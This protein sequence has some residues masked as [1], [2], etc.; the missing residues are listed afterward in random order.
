MRAGV[1]IV[2]SLLWDTKNGRQEWREKRLAMHRQMRVKV[3]ISYGRRSS[4][5]GNTFTMTLV[6][7]GGPLGEAIL[8]PCAVDP[9]D[10]LDL[11]TEA[12]SLWKAEQPK[13]PPESIAAQW[14]C[15]GVSFGAALHQSDWS[16]RW[17][18]H[19]ATRACAVPPVTA[20][21]HVNI[22]WPVVVGD[23]ELD[24]DLVLATATKA[25]TERPKPNEIADAWVHQ[26]GG[27]EQYFFENVRCGIRTPDDASIWKRIEEAKPGWLA[28]PDY[29][30]AVAKLR[31]EAICRLAEQAG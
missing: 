20:D 12:E 30:V 6:G 22:S 26:Q 15:V 11:V 14:G 7:D 2:G 4:T 16:Q 25:A 21:G 3:P 9:I 24:R 5:R 29:R 8:V 13:A 31:N 18:A 27:Y 17:A 1:L 19:F 10:F 28:R 23:G